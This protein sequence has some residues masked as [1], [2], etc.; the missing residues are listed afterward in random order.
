MV[1]NKA[2]IGIRK[3]LIQ[4]VYCIIH[5]LKTIVTISDCVLLV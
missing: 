1:I 2:R 4:V 5:F 3:V